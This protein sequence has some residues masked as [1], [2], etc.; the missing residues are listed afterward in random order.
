MKLDS[1]DQTVTPSACIL[2]MGMDASRCV[3][4][5]LQT[6]IMSTAVYSLPLVDSKLSIIYVSSYRS[7]SF[8][9]FRFI[10][11]LYLRIWTSTIFISVL[12]II[13]SEFLNFIKWIKRNN[14]LFSVSEYNFVFFKNIFLSL[15]HIW[16]TR[17]Q[18]KN[19]WW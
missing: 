9:V 17:Q 4:A 14:V 13:L 10:T 18:Q 3:I 16:T 11:L 7:A 19:R 5:V 2:H 12:K 6:G 8:H 15:Q 1:V